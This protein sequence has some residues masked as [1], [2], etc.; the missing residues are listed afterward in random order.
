M[1][2]I[3]CI[4]FVLFV[5][6]GTLCGC[7]AKDPDENSGGTTFDLTAPEKAD[8][9][10]FVFPDYEKRGLIKNIKKL[11]E[12]SQDCEVYEFVYPSDK[13]KV[14]GMVAIP[15]ECIET[16]TPISA[17]VY[18][19]GGNSNMGFL[20]GEEIASMCV[21]SNRVVIASQYRGANGAEGKD[22]FGGADL[23][24]VT[25]LID[26][27][28]KE[29]R[30]I[31]LENLCMVGVSR[32]GMMSYMVAKEDKRVKGVVAVSAVT[33][34]AASYNEREDMKNILHSA[35]GG[36]PEE[37]PEEYAKRSAVN[38]ANELDVPVFIIHSKSDELVSYSQAKEMNELLKDSKHGCTMITHLDDVHGF[39][40]EDAESIVQW[41]DQTLPANPVQN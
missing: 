18:N 38:W 39:H 22:E 41:L 9:N 10:W 31:N 20:T 14:K 34:L 8:I 25:S 5:F 19:R 29:F 24:D 26:L 32:G 37:L 27:C 13:Y 3:L 17:I 21:A 28:E 2:R 11:S 16:E 1:K 33:D 15:S 23:E 40:P 30:F 4:A 7:N 6:A 35:I 36:S 12:Y